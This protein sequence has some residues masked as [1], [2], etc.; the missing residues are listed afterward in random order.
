MTSILI[1]VIHLCYNIDIIIYVPS[2]TTMCFVVTQLS[3]TV[4]LQDHHQDESLLKR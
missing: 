2:N 3:I 1:V 4:F